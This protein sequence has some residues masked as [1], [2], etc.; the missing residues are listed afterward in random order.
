M[1]IV[2]TCWGS[3]GD[4]FPYV[5]LGRT[6][7][8]RG[9]RV[10]LGLPSFYR[11]LVEGQRLDFHPV[12]PEVDPSQREI[13]AR[14]MDPRRGPEVIIREWLMPALRQQYADVADA[15]RDADL[16]VTHPVTFAGPLLAQTRALPWVSTVLA[17]LS[18]FSA[19]DLPVFP[20]ATRQLR[21]GTWFGRL[22]GAMV[23]RATREWWTPVRDLR[24]ELGLPAGGN[25]IFEA[26]FSPT[27]TLAMFSRVMA[28]P[29]PDWPPHAH[30]T[31]FV[32]YN[33][34]ESLDPVLERFL[35][36]GPPPVVFTLGSSAVGAAG[37]FYEE[38]AAAAVRLGV[39]AVLLRGPY[40]DNNPSRTTSPDVLVIERAP[41]QL[42]FPRASAIVHQG[43]VGTTGQALRSGKPTL[44]V[45]HSH[46]Q[47]DNAARVRRLGVART[48]VPGQ[49]KAQR[50]VRELD[51]LL[52][53]TSYRDHGSRVAA[54]I[55][56]EDGANRAAD[57]IERVR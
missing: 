8:A 4:V 15:A 11:S 37:D 46:D 54:T 29:Q 36:A 56:A 17:P 34:P 49:Y 33:G 7:Q 24:R 40:E 12:G 10:R 47:P 1:R 3:F 31:G 48:L 14:V 50:V 44:V 5:G 43:G 45:P 26:Q 25:P 2:I 52:S 51:R 32:F 38:S 23:R 18:F 53:D 28:Q 39:R 16:L 42:L 21:L 35:D 55:A 30:V 13:I 41:H 27:L 57:L 22:M 9:H 19:Y 20:G 6:L